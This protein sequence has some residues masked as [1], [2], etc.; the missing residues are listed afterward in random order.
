VTMTGDAD[1]IIAVA[2]TGL[3]TGVLT[4][5][6]PDLACRVRV[7]SRRRHRRAQR[8]GPA[9]SGT[10][11]DAGCPGDRAV[12]RR[13]ARSSRDRRIALHPGRSPDR[14]SRAAHAGLQ[15]RCPHPCSGLGERGGW[16]VRQRLVRSRTVPA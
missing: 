13:R 9:R 7:G 11:C 3:D 8:G 1:E 4:T 2:H 10:G 6:T 12:D 15:V 14:P 5:I 16:D